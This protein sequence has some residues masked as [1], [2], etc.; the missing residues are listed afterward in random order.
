M[1]SVL[2]QEAG[3]R[4]GPCCSRARQRR[5][6]DAIADFRVGPVVKQLA[7]C[8]DMP[9]GRGQVQWSHAGLMVSDVTTC[10]QSQ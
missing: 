1:G 4:G 10:S 3:D 6:A 8:I 7:C 9:V 5:P 2:E